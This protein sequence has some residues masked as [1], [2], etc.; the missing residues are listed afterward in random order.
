[1]DSRALRQAIDRIRD[2]ALHLTDEELAGSGDRAARRTQAQALNTRLDELWRQVE[3]I[4][5]DDRAT[6]EDAWHAAQRYLIFLLATNDVATDDPHQLARQVSGEALDLAK[7]AVLG[8]G[9]QAA[10]ERQARAL[11]ARLDELLPRVDKSQP[12]IQRAL[13]DATLDIYYIL[14]GGAGAVSLRLAHFI[15]ERREAAGGR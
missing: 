11:L 2:E 8:R 15:R 4:P 5:P 14:Q 3:R 1:M 9:D 12:D 7:A 13:T 10:R 6:L